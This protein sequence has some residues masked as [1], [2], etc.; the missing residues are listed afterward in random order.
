ME[1]A[2]SLDLRK[3]GIKYRENHS[4][5]QT[6]D[7]VNIS[8]STISD[9]ELL[10]AETGSFEK[11]PLDRSDKKINPVELAAFIIEKPDSYLY[12][13]AEHFN[14][15]I[16]AVS[17]ALD[18]QNITLKKL[19][20]VIAPPTKPCVLA[21]RI[22]VVRWRGKAAGILAPFKALLCRLAAKG[23][24]IR[25]K[26]SLGEQYREANEKEREAFTEALAEIEGKNSEK[27]TYY[28]DETGIDKYYFATKLKH[29]LA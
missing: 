8:I 26:V 2:Y 20:F 15:S 12:E 24:V 4:L 3:K 10:L 22:F 16:M 5:E 21:R 29:F 17:Y 11:R 19:K 28:V 6:R 25:C 27:H 13:I 23:R 9:W 7:T 18:K 14:C 1:M